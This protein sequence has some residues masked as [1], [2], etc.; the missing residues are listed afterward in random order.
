[1]QKRAVIDSG[2]LIALFDKDD[3]LHTKVM[4]FF[5]SFAGKLYSTLAVVTELTHMLDFNVSTQIDFLKWV[6]NGGIELVD[7]TEKDLVQVCTLTE[8]YSDIPMDFADASLVLIAEKLQIRL[9]ISIDSDFYIYRTLSDGYL[10][11][12]MDLQ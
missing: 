11:N 3:S 6:A 9:C 4:E 1:M 5:Q 8:K 2:P 12:L 10:E 7:L